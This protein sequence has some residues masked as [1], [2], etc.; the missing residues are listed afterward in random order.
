MGMPGQPPPEEQKEEVRVGLGAGCCAGW[1]L[2]CPA[3]PLPIYP[4][5]PPFSRLLP[6]SPTAPTLSLSP[7]KQQPAKVPYQ[8]LIVSVLRE[9][10]ERDLAVQG[11][12][13]PLDKERLYDDFGAP[14]A[15]RRAAPRCAVLCCCSAPAFVL[16]QP[17]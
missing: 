11:C 4:P 12:P 13:F 9:Y 5:P 7:S 16:R 10:L 17:L 6:C 8:F 2:P 15:C 14:S 3:Q 1:S